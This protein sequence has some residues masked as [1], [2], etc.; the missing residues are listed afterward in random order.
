MSNPI[1]EFERC[2]LK[3]YKNLDYNILK[4]I[5]NTIFSNKQIKSDNYNNFIIG[6][7]NSID[8]CYDNISITYTNCYMSFNKSGLT[9]NC[10][11]PHSYTAINKYLNCLETWLKYIY[12]EEE[13]M[14][15]ISYC[16]FYI[17]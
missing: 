16:M 2:L 3:N 13:I 17:I 8:I 6:D 7:I 1:F 14:D 12:N 15:I 10:V 5:F 4:D 9:I 11:P